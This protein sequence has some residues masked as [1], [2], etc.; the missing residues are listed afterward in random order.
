MDGAGNLKWF[1]IPEDEF[2]AW[3]EENREEAGG[4]SPVEEEEAMD[5]DADE[6]MDADAEE[7]MDL[8]AEMDI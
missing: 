7:E 3:L 2:Q 5:A 8:D 1:L 6:E 4:Q